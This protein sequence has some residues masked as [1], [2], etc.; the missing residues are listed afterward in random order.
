MTIHFQIIIV[1]S[2]FFHILEGTALKFGRVEQIFFGELVIK[3]L[4]PHSE[5]LVLMNRKRVEEELGKDIFRDVAHI[6]EFIPHANPVARTQTHEH[7]LEHPRQH[8]H[9]L[10]PQL[11]QVQHNPE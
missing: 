11:D 3:F 8:R 9:S 10:A 7:D 4:L 2:I 6:S 1:L 5:F